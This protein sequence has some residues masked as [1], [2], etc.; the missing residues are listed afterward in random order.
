MDVF[1]TI[2][3]RFAG[4]GVVESSIGYLASQS[5]YAGRYGAYADLPERAYVGDEPK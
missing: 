2:T 1:G 3:I 4:L 5:S